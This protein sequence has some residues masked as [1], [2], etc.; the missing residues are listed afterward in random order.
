MDHAEL[1]KRLK[2]ARLAKKMTQSDVVGTFI[3]RNM[4]SQI[5]SGTATPSMNTLEYLAGV[6]EIPMDRLFDDPET[7]H[8]PGGSAVLTEAKCHLRE[9]RYE[10]V[11]ALEDASGQ[12]E[13]ELPALRSIA[14]LV[15]AR[16]IADSGQ[17]ENLQTAVMYARDAAK[18]AM[19]GIYANADR[20]AQA[21]QFI[22]NV[23]QYLS[24][25]YSGLA[26][27]G[28]GLAED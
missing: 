15:L 3:T 7:V 8:P 22:A 19:L 2:A 20:A 16:R 12:V 11:L 9:H 17:A 5:E 10:A 18:E 13:D 23:A 6:L 1:G 28:S 26:R 25:Y 14:G 24:T 21:N 27:D 4:L